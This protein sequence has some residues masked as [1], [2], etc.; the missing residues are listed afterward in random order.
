VRARGV[1]GNGHSRAGMP[2]LNQR[3]T[4]TLRHS[5]VRSVDAAPWG[6]RPSTRPE[7][8]RRSCRG[9]STRRAHEDPA[10]TQYL[11]KALLACHILA[12]G[13]LDPHRGPASR[14]DG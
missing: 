2:K 4:P 6:L 5:S 8:A 13:A 1:G 14:P 11:R 3:A 7:P 9:R 12:A 10:P